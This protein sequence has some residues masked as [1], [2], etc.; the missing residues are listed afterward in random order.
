M[1]GYFRKPII[2]IILLSLLFIFTKEAYS[3]PIRGSA[4]TIDSPSY[5]LK[6][7]TYVPLILAC[8]AHDLNW[9]WD[10]IGKVVILKKGNLEARLQVESYKLYVNGRIKKLE[11]PILLHKGIVL[12]P[13]SFAKRT[14]G[15]I[16]TKEVIYKAKI[17]PPS[18]TKRYTI[19][20]I[21]IDPGHGGKDPGAVGSYGLRE[22][23]LVLEVSKI[24]R[25]ELEAEG[26]KVLLTRDRDVFI[27]LGRRAAIANNKDADFFVSV[28]VNAAR[29]RRAKG[30][31]AY[32]LSEASDDSARALAAAENASLKYEE[33]SFDM[34]TARLDATLW[35]IELDEQKRE[36]KGLADAICYAVSKK[37]AVRNRGTKSARFYVL[38]GV[39]MPAVLVE[40]GFISNSK[41]ASSLKSSYYRKKMAEA[42][43]N[44]ILSYKRRYERTNGFTQ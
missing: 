39:R 13:I 32:Y 35:D 31:E 33:E 42:L 34:H 21:V 43:A 28:H 5:K 7:T 41:E 4:S 27:P 36:S 1:N 23:D 12:V 40:L 25:R 14:L 15:K 22:K 30:F 38:K 44:G 2:S 26:I 37:L 10:P 9:E 19:D 29:A 11:K 6:R 17:T 8:E 24:L 3:I 16:F 20:T 18:I